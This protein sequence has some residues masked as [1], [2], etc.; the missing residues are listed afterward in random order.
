MES[1]SFF[2]QLFKQLPQTL[3]EALDLPAVLAKSYR[4]D[5]VEVKKSFR[6]DGLFVPDRLT[7]PIR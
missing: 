2:C 3:F 4:F 7:L 6:I 1:D 5:S